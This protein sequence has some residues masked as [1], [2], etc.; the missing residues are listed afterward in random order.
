MISISL[1]YFIFVSGFCI[2]LGFLAYKTKIVDMYGF[3]SG[4][5]ISFA[6]LVFVGQYYFTVFFA[7]VI[8]GGIVS[9]YEYRKKK[10]NKVAEKESGRS[11]SNVL[12]NGAPPLIFAAL[13]GL[14]SDP[15]MLCGFVCAISAIAADTA[16]SEIGVLSKKD[17]FLIT[18][19]KRVKKGTDGGVSMLGLSASIFGAFLMSAIAAVLQD[20]GLRIFL[21]S[22][23]SGFIGGLV[24]SFFGATL[25][26]RKIF[27][28]HMT[29]FICGLS[30]GVVGV[31]LYLK[32]II[33]V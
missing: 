12:G 10:K 30:G 24:D 3:L 7:F 31:F 17:P 2:L 22:V 13:Y 20:L 6:V 29:N 25:E 26:R 16:A 15:I 5:V 11:I 21:I 14:T 33:L 18:T 4:A 19:F 8:F 9:A 1:E 23:V 27:D 32:W 28:K